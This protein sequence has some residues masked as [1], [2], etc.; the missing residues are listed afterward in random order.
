MLYECASSN[1][2]PQGETIV[3]E[4]EEETLKKVKVS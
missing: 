2:E 4:T 3:Y 1:K